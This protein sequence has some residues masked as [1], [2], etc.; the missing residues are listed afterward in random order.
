MSLCY[1]PYRWPRLLLPINLPAVFY[2]NEKET[3]EAVN[4]AEVVASG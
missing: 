1:L 3:C 4:V 2:G